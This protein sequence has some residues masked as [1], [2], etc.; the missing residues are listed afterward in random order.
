MTKV[1]TF[2]YFLINE[3]YFFSDEFEKSDIFV[4]YCSEYMQTRSINQSISPSIDKYE[5]NHKVLSVA[6]PQVTTGG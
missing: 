5:T 3:L 1:N 2:S 4:L 6:V